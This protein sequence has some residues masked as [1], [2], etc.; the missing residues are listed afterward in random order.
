MRQGTESAAEADIDAH[1]GDVAQAAFYDDPRVLTISLHQHP[2]MLFSCTGLPAS[3]GRPGAEGSAVNVALPGRVRDTSWLRA[4][5]AIIPSLP[6]QFRQ[7]ALVSEHGCDT[8]RLDLLAHLEL[9]I[10]V[11]RVA[12]AAVHALARG[13]AD[14]RWVL[15]GGGNDLVH[16]V[17]STPA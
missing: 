11:Q 1:H 8:Q 9:S 12:R 5:H 14:G 6:W 13:L 10:E 16:V 17:P 7:H 4:F 2:A 3:T 15:T